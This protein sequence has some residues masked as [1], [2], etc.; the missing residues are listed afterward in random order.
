MKQNEYYKHSILIFNK[1]FYYTSVQ[2]KLE[3]LELV[4]YY[5]YSNQSQDN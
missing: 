1:L 2:T 3:Q 4:I 5:G